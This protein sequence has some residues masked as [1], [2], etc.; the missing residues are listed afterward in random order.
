[1]YT[2]H[3][4]HTQQCQHTHTRDLGLLQSFREIRCTHAHTHTHTY[5]HARALSHE[6][7]RR[8]SLCVYRSLSC[9]MVARF[10][11]QCMHSFSHRRFSIS[12]TSS[13]F[14]RPISSNAAVFDTAS[15]LRRIKS[16]HEV[17]KL[18][19]W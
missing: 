8:S 10:V 14:D 6:M 1:M 13:T 9:A 2:Y 15:K 4:L 12:N 18:L 16:R 11:Q 5:T 17:R 19:A 3:F 7:E